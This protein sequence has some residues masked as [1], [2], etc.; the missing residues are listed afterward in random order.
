MNITDITWILKEGLRYLYYDKNCESLDELLDYVNE[1]EYNKS[2]LAEAF[3]K[4]IKHLPEEV[5]KELYEKLPRKNMK[6]GTFQ[7]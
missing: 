7:L 5:K 4:F 6:D 3:I 2:E 1:E